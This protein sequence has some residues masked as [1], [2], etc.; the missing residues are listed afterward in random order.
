MTVT[1]PMA[2]VLVRDASAPC[3]TPEA[4]AERQRCFELIK[5]A[6]NWKLPIDA[7]IRLEDFDDANEAAMWFTNGDLLRVEVVGADASR[8]RVTSPGYYENVGA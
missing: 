3:H 2:W 1:M 7:V 5:P 4:E 6:G 8:I